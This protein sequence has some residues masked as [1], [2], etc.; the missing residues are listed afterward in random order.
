MGFGLVQDWDIKTTAG[1]CLWDR[2]IFAFVG[3][4]G[5][6]CPLKSLQ[7]K[8]NVQAQRISASSK[9]LSFVTPQEASWLE[10]RPFTV[11]DTYCYLGNARRETIIHCEMAGFGCCDSMSLGSKAACCLLNSLNTSTFP[12]PCVRQSLSSRQY[13]CGDVSFPCYKGP[14][15]REPVHMSV[16]SSEK[17]SNFTRLLH[18]ALRILIYHFWCH[19]SPWLAYARR[20]L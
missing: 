1:L 18:P 15:H 17:L 20:P 3:L 5:G 19:M 6:F 13:F 11:R 4:F 8:I 2:N 16:N 10:V 7:G 12:H 9:A 14:Y